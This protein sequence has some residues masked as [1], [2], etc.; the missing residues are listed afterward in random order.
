MYFIP[1]CPV[2]TGVVL[3]LFDHIGDDLSPI[4][5]GKVRQIVKIILVPEPIDGFGPRPEVPPN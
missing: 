3:F 4:A 1:D 2:A 5:I